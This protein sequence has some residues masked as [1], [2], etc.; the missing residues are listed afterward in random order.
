M[1]VEANATVFAHGIVGGATTPLFPPGGF[2]WLLPLYVVG[3]IALNVY[4]L[5]RAGARW[6]SACAGAVY[7]FLL[8]WLVCFAIGV[9][10]RFVSSEV[11]PGFGWP[12]ER[13]LLGA[14]WTLWPVFAFWNFVAILVLRQILLWELRSDLP[15]APQKRRCFRLNAA[16]YLAA[17]VPFLVTGAMM[18]GWTGGHVR[19]ACDSNLREMGV[20][21]ALYAL[22]ND[23]RLPDGRSIEAVRDAVDPAYRRA[24]PDLDSLATICPMGEI[25]ERNPRPYEWDPAFAGASLGDLAR[26]RTWRWLIRCPYHEGTSLTVADLLRT[27][28]R[29]A[30]EDATRSSQRPPSALH[31]PAPAE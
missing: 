7:T 30:A 29:L 2:I 8:F 9:A 12:G 31:Q 24:C 4:L 17:L 1:L 5:R 13:A 15:E 14:G 6:F 18:Q 19:A 10:V 28:E 26:E 16:V 25:I 20:A 27:A 21:V 11:L 22:E 23:G 3:F